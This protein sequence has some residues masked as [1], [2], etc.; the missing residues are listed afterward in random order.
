[1]E[2]K[3]E[4]YLIKENKDLVACN[5]YVSNGVIL[6]SKHI[7]K[8][9]LLL[10]YK[11]RE[12]DLLE[13]IDLPFEQG[14]EWELPNSVELGSFG[15]KYFA[16]NEKYRFDYDY[17]KLFHSVYYLSIEFYI[18]WFCNA[19]VLKVFIDDNFA[20]VIMPAKIN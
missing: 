6:V 10:A 20:G 15:K 3:L 8:N 13:T 9:K 17:I 2:N 19:P 14:E 11:T 18:V 4:E 1:M 7:L 5:K 16:Y 12:K